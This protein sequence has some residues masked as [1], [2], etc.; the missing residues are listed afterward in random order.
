MIF[1]VTHLKIHLVEHVHMDHADHFGFWWNFTLMWKHVTKKMILGKRHFLRLAWTWINSLEV[2][3]QKPPSVRKLPQR[4][5]FLKNRHFCNFETLYFFQKRRGPKFH[6]IWCAF[7]G[8]ISH[9][10][11]IQ[12]RKLKLIEV[13]I[14]GKLTATTT[15]TAAASQQLCPPGKAPWPSRRGSKYLVQES[16]TSIWNE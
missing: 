15:T 11:P 4:F 13:S 1:W 5:L 3:F 7:R 2:Y 10:R 8:E 6:E 12:A 14:C 9:M 16:L